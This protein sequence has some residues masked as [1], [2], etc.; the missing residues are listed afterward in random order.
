MTNLPFFM[1]CE[2]SNNYELLVGGL[3]I[4][5]S[6]SIT[7]GIG[8]GDGS[9]FINSY[10]IGIDILISIDNFW[11]IASTCSSIIIRD[12]G[13]GDTCCARNLDRG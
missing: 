10:N 1:G 7:I 13:M 4:G 3:K 2:G 6:S 12:G 9:R 8:E 5:F 11:I